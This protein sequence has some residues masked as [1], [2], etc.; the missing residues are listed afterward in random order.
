MNEPPPSPEKAE[1]GLSLLLPLIFSI[2]VLLF[3][4]LLLLLSSLRV[5]LVQLEN[6]CLALIGAHQLLGFCTNKFGS[7]YE[8]I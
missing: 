3:L 6:K 2:L 7:I 1:L 8:K 5:D 4:N